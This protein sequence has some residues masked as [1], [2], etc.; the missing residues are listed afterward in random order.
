M[1]KLTW[2]E[3][4]LGSDLEVVLKIGEYQIKN[5]RLE[6]AGTV[7]ELIQHIDRVIIGR[8]LTIGDDKTFYISNEYLVDVLEKLE[9]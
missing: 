3:E 9:G 7:I 1:R 8:E 5:V 2:M 4:I 6:A